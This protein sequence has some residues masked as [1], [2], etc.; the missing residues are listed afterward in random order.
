MLLTMA[1]GMDKVR[2]VL[3]NILAT[4]LRTE[5]INHLGRDVDSRFNLATLSGF[6]E[7]IVIPR[8][9]AADCVLDFFR[10]DE[11]LLEFIAY[12]ISRQGFGATG[13]VIK[14]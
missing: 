1:A 8:K 6:G 5:Q 7:K 10:G 11:Q 13:G 9:V 3:H 2:R 4:S 12:M 14:A